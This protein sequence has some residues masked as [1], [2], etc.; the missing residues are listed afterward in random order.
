MTNSVKSF[1]HAVL[2]IL[3]LSITVNLTANP[4]SETVTIKTSASCESCKARLEKILKSYEGVEEAILNLNNKKLK[5]RFDS[6]ITNAGRLR[7]VISNA[8]YDADDVKKNAEGFN[9]LPQ[10]CQKPMK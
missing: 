6:A 8:G 9:K 7:E 4:K 10:C 1:F 2:L 3:V 5:V